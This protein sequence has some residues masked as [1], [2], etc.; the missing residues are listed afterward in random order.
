MQTLFTHLLLAFAKLHCAHVQPPFLHTS[1]CWHTA[2]H[3]PQLLLS[4]ATFTSQPFFVA[5][6]QSKNPT[7]HLEMK[8]V[9]FAHA[10]CAF[11]RNPHAVPHA[12]QFFASESTLVSQPSIAS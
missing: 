9:A 2:P 4:I 1:P 8:H 6:S 5:P 11:G 12:A 10:T 3:A 7:V